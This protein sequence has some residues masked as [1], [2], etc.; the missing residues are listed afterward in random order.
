[1]ARRG[2]GSAWFAC[3]RYDPAG[4]FLVANGFDGVA[5]LQDVFMANTTV[6]IGGTAA[7][8]AGAGQPP[9]P[10]AWAAAFAAALPY[11][12]FLDRH[13]TA[14][15]RARW[16]AVHARI[17]LQPAQRSLLGGFVR[18]M[19]V[20]VLSGAWCGDCVNQCPI[21]ARFAEASPVLDVR[22]LDRDAL[23]DI[24]AHL[25]VCGGQRVP[26]AAFFS[27]DFTPVLYYGDRT[28]SAYRAAAVAQ[29]GTSCASG[30]V[31]PA[32]DAV[33]AVITD[34]LEQ[35]ERVQLILRLSGR[36]RELHGD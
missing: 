31:P 8:V 22:F 18:R 7:P 35:F 24:A 26:V 28:L 3:G 9:T 2:G 4:K 11:R 15:Q 13:A 17:T 20:L 6:S 29:L 1:V 5:S 36:L 14:E 21:F 30:A 25:K 16:D 10:V 27:E 34:W 33:A 19:P 32:A 23:P 12:E